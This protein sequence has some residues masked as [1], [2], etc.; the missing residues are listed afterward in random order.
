MKKLY[1]M[2]L[3][4]MFALVPMLFGA[5]ENDVVNQSV[6]PTVKS[7]LR[8]NFWDFETGLQ[9]WTHSNGLPFPAGWD[10]KPSN[11]IPSYILPDAGDSTMWIDAGQGGG[12]FW[13]QDTAL[14]PAVVPP[15]NM[16]WLKYGY[17]N[18][19]Y[20][21]YFY[22]ELHVGIRFFT[23]GV[24]NT[25][26]LQFYPASATSGPA[27]DSVDVSA[28]STV[29]SV[30]VYFY[31]D[32]FY[33]WGYQAAFDNVEL[34]EPIVHDVGCV[35][36]TSPPGGYITPGDYDVIGQIQNFGGDSETFDVTAEVWDTT[37]R[38]QI[39]AQTVTLT[40]FPVG[41]DTLLNFGTATF[42]SDKV[43][44]TEIFTLLS[45]DL[46][47]S[48]DTSSIYSTTQLSG[49][50]PLFEMDV[51]TPTGDSA[52]IGVEF[53]GTYF[54]VTGGNNG[55]DPNKVYVIDTLGN[56]IWAVDQ[57]GHSTG[58]GWR[59]LAWDN[60]YSGPD[61]IDTLWASV[62]PNI[63]GFSIDLTT[64][65]LTWHGSYSGQQ[66]PNRALAWMDDSAWFWTA[67]FSSPVY[68]FDKFGN[69]GSASNT[70]SMCGAAYDTDS[71]YGG[72]I[73]WHSRDDPGTGWA[74]QIEQFDPFTMIF[75]G[76]NFG[77]MPTI[78]VPQSACGLCF[79][80]G[81]RGCD[82][83]FALV[84]GDPVDAIIGL[85]VRDHIPGVEEE[86]GK[87]MELVF[88][89]KKIAPNPVRD[90]ATVTYTT[91]RKGPVMLKVYDSAGRL[92]RTLV[93]RNED[94]GVK[95]VYWD[96]MDNNR[97][98]VAAGVYFFRLQAEDR[99]ATKKIVVV[100]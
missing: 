74:G 50:V 71:I 57:P 81:F 30:R 68:W 97:Q 34:F 56:L 22:N 65:T 12:T 15:I 35:A 98:P 44:Y 73:W 21:G 4:L 70:W 2:L 25:V 55:T 6:L 31:F 79:Y 59:D 26:E 16:V 92:I 60:A 41:G 53:D 54:Y 62:D 90:R 23:S 100:R 67:N 17:V 87:E 88:G 63:D 82:V 11:Y 84:Q 24:W 51:Q 46:N 40:D 36:V 3:F 33:T 29:D 7:D 28:Y 27:W 72:W 89:L 18:V 10:V 91:T 5:Y 32:D 78:T 20:V 14:S 9:G 49:P 37:T 64:G 1:V 83:L 58:W 94:A 48:N 13:I 42:D 38:T 75:T 86:P 93:D 77:Y 80:E 47:P 45:Y 85:Y 95:T 76:F 8:D 43:F 99:T 52:C 61:K 96:G 39:F 19:T 69:S 66:S